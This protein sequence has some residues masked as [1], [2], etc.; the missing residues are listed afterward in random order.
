MNLSCVLK[1]LKFSLW[2]RKY[3]TSIIISCSITKPNTIIRKINGKHLDGKS[4]KDV[5]AIYF[6]NTTVNYFP[7]GLNKIF[8]NLKAVIIHK[9]GLKSIT[10]RDLVALENIEILRCKHNKISSLPYNLFRSMHKLRVISFYDNSLQFMSSEVLRPILENDVKFVDFCENRSLSVYYCGPS[11]MHKKSENKVDSVAQ[12]MAMIDEKCDKPMNDNYNRIRNVASEGFKE[13]WTTGRFSEITIVSDTEKFKAH[14]F[15]LAI[16]S[17]VFSSIFE[18]EM[19]DQPSDEIQLTN[20]KPEVVKIF[21]KFL[22]TGDI[23]IEGSNL[24]ELFTLAAKF[25][26]ENLMTIVE[27]MNTDDLNDDNAI[28]IFELACRFDC[29]GMKTSAFGVIQLMFDEPLKDELM[30]QP[31]VVKNLVKA[32]SMIGNYEKCIESLQLARDH[33]LS[34]RLMD[35]LENNCREL[36]QS[37]KPRK[38]LWDIFNLSHPPNPR[39]PQISNC[40]ELRE[41]EN[42][43][44]HIV[45]NKKLRPGDVIAIEKPFFKFLNS[46]AMNVYKYERCFDCLRRNHLSLL[47]TS[48][49]VMA[50]STFCQ[51]SIEGKSQNSSNLFETQ[52]NWEIAKMIQLRNESEKICGTVENLENLVNEPLKTVFDFDWIDGRSA[53]LKKNL[54]KCV[55]SLSSGNYNQISSDDTEIFKLF[56]G[57]Y[58]DHNRSFISGFVQHMMGVCARNQYSLQ[59]FDGLS[60]FYGELGNCL[61]P[62]GSLI[63][64]SCN[65]NVFWIFIENKFV[66]VV[67]KPIEKNE[68][69]FHCYRH[70]FL[71]EPLNDRQSHLMRQYGF[72]CKCDACT[73]I[74]PT[75]PKVFKIN[76]KK[77]FSSLEEI[78]AEVSQNWIDIEVDCYREMFVEVAEKININKKLLEYVVW[79][80]F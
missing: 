15:V 51:N 71:Y 9:C 49:S 2:G 24:L 30:N 72:K 78:L 68:Q 35:E 22:Y 18:N 67:A 10:Q 64:H 40:L 76:P 13:F 26:V 21:L 52:F 45:T 80:Y 5:E 60:D 75:Y 19:K 28:E 69:L 39:F 33:G 48:N 36:I 66:F 32:N 4:D 27:E 44:R 31:E 14:K 46:N 43:G 58:N 17:S 8:P 12:L 54:L 16:Q 29:D 20:I 38:N 7:L 61:L 73:Q 56:L 74:Y 63:N 6:T 55:V 77:F 57:H 42:F 59:F 53:E 62:F 37:S 50:C 11:Y 79:K 41:N 47:P 3:Y 1:N 25:K 23:E 34:S 70:V 65:P